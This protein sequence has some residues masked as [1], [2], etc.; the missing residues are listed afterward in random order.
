MKTLGN[1]LWHFPFFGFL[2]AL[3]NLLIGLIL[4][5][6]IIGSPIGLGIVELAKFQMSP[7]KKTMVVGDKIVDNRGT[8]RRIFEAIMFIIYLPFGLIMAAFTISQIILL[9]ITIIGIPAAVVLAKSLGTYFNPIGKKCVSRI[10]AEELERAVAKE[11]I[12]SS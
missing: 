2:T 4:I 8:A 3:G 5:I 1:I 7:F 12:Y 10:Y 6:T 9:L 11:K